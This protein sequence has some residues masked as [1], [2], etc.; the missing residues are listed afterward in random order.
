M[1]IKMMIRSTKR[2]K[3]LN[4]IRRQIAKRGRWT[5]CIPNSVIIKRMN[6]LRVNIKWC[7]IIVIPKVIA[8]P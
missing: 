8:L 5:L 6:S 4:W 2:P 3:F 1:V 7:R